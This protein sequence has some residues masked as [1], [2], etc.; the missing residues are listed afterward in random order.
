MRAIA[1]G[2]AERALEEAVELD[3]SGGL[4]LVQVG[5]HFRVRQPEISKPGARDSVVTPL[6]DC[7][8]ANDTDPGNFASTAKC[9]ND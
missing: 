8:S 2:Y 1:G 5:E 7:A 6:A 9:I 3:T 4:A